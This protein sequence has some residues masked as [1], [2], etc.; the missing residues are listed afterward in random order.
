MIITN[1]RKMI[2]LLIFATGCFL[3]FFNSSIYDFVSEANNII[4]KGSNTNEQKPLMVHDVFSPILIIIGT[5][6]AAAVFAVYFLE[7]SLEKR[8]NLDRSTNAILRELRENQNVLSGD[9]YEQIKYTIK[10][11]VKQD[12]H[13]SIQFFINYTNAYLEID[14]YESVLYSGL[15][16]HFSLI[17]QH[18]LTMLY[19][20]IRDR[21][22]LLVYIEQFE[23][24]FFLNDNS[25]ERKNLWY[26]KI[27]KYDILL[28][29]WEKEIR[30]LFVTAELL[31]KKERPHSYR[32]KNLQR[33]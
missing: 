9:F 10:N 15:F 20:R 3:I 4:L 33:E 31:V 29:E 13:S 26:K 5:L 14:S 22:K 25:N 24:N 8:N 6:G 23:D 12:E 21:N 18:T 7:R 28:T 2:Y 11:A 32:L 30:D 1:R 19:S 27:Q 16:T 17:T